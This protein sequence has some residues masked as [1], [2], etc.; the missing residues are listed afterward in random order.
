MR[1]VATQL[2]FL[3]TILFWPA[4]F[5]GSLILHARGKSKPTSWML[6]GATTACLGAAIRFLYQFV[7]MRAPATS[8]DPTSSAPDIFFIGL[9]LTALG[10]ILFAFSFV[11]YARSRPKV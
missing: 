7:A 11:Q 3:G 6:V 5:A 8:A 2:T 10:Y 1:F 4:F 9:I